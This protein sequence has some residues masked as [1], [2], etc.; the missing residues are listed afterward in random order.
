MVTQVLRIPI[1]L[2]SIIRLLAIDLFMEAKETSDFSI[3]CLLAH[4]YSKSAIAAILPEYCSHRYPLN[5]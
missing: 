4:C 3:F 2:Q 5:G 1:N